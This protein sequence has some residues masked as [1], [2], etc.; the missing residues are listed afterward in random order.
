MTCRKRRNEV[1]RYFRRLKAYRRVF[2]R[3]DKLDIL[4]SS[5]VTVARICEILADSVDTTGL[6]HRTP[7][8][9][10]RRIP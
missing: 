6:T 8:F 2:A 7:T 4:Y 3:Y 5:F 10:K 9:T 1:E